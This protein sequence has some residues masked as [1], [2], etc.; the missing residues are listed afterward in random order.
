[1]HR[2]LFVEAQ[3]AFF[4]RGQTAAGDP[5]GARHKPLPGGV[6]RRR[7]DLN[8]AILQRHRDPIVARRHREP[9]AVLGRGRVGRDG[10]QGIVDEIVDPEPP[11]PG[12]NGE[13]CAA[14][15]LTSRTRGK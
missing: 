14:S 10:A 7:E 3:V 5:L 15:L 4:R 9:V 2:R 13:P 1:M 8:V 12:R 11:F 6:A